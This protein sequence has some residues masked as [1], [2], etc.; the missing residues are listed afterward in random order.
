MNI[1]N[2]IMALLASSLLVSVETKAEILALQDYTGLE[3]GEDAIAGQ[4]KTCGV[5]KFNNA[6]GPQCGSYNITVSDNRCA[7]KSYVASRTAKCGVELYLEKKDKSCPGYVPF[8]RKEASARN[9]YEGYIMKIVRNPTSCDSEFKSCRSDSGWA[10]FERP[11]VIKSCRSANFGVELYKLCA[12]PSHGVSEYESCNVFGG[13]NTCEHGDFGVASYKSCQIGTQNRTCSVYKRPEELE[14]WVTEQKEQIGF[15]AP[16]LLNFS[17]IVVRESQSQIGFVCYINSV[18]FGTYLNEDIALQTKV[19]ADLEQ[20]YLEKYSATL[21]SFPVEGLDC[22]NIFPQLP[23]R[24]CNGSD[25]SSLGRAVC[26]VEDSK[27]ALNAIQ[28]NLTVV[29]NGNGNLTNSDAMNH[30]LDEI[31]E[32]I[33][34]AIQRN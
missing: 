2:K 12:D 22:N 24:E 15:L 33:N 13:Y 26:G 14:D 11:E 32:Q 28:S 23:A 7:V 4:S 30:R 8:D 29:R 1:S 27:R 34:Y 18:K 17:G 25:S 3:C 16:M 20:L 31:I 6:Q 9:F 5:E 10:I 19:I 21:S